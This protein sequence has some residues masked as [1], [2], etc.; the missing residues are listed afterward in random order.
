MLARTATAR[1]PRLSTTISELVRS[2]ATARKRIGSLSKSSSPWRAVSWRSTA[3]IE[4]PAT[5]PL[6]SAIESPCSPTSGPT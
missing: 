6:G 1:L 5:T 4:M 2:V 3:S